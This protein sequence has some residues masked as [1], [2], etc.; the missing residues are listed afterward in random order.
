M[1]FVCEL[2]RLGHHE[3]CRGKTWC[4]CQHKGRK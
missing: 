1:R 4:D 3:D 2:C